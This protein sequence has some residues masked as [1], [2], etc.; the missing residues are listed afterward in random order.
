MSSLRARAAQRRAEEQLKRSDRRFHE[1]FDQAPVGIAHVGPDGRIIV[2]NR[3]LGKML[4][5]EQR[6][7]VGFSVKDLSHPD[8]RDLVDPLP[9]RIRSGQLEAVT[10]QKR[11]LRKDGS[12]VWVELTI[13]IMRDSD[14]N[15]AYDVTVVEDISKRKETEGALRRLNSLYSALAETNEAIAR[16]KDRDRLFQEVCAIAVR[17]GGFKTAAIWL[18]DL[19]IRKIRVA[20]AAGAGIAQ[21]TAL[22]SLMEERAQWGRGPTLLALREGRHSVNNDL[23]GNVDDAYPPLIGVGFAASAAFPLKLQGEVIG[24]LS[25]YSGE[26]GAFDE[27]L[28][29]LLAHLAENVSF[30]LDGI[31]RD[32]RRTEAEQALRDSEARYRELTELSADWYWEQDRHYR[33]TA[34]S[35]PIGKHGQAPCAGLHRQNPLGTARAERLRS[36]PGGTPGSARCAHAVPRP[37]AGARSGWTAASSTSA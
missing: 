34:F 25:L 5:Y 3:C 9:A 19:D 30:A 22:Q 17:H 32:A 13:S 2:A 12:T 27:A 28:V 31:D 20:A 11:Y 37:H 18:G 16:I 10:K 33:F 15:P 14:G 1:T 29:D 24:T 23:L 36:R 4:G 8:D 26:L 21:L 6:E 35:G 7:L